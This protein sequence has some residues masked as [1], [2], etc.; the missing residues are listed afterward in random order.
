MART[1]LVFSH[2]AV[3]MPLMAVSTLGTVALCPQGKHP[4][5]VAIQV[6]FILKC[7]CS[8]GKHR[9]SSSGVQMRTT[10]KNEKVLYLWAFCR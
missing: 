6:V 9:G 1:Q 5:A 10:N 7:V 3:V 8:A 4:L 2:H